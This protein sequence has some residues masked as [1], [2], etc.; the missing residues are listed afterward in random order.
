M[1]QY[2]V[3]F[4]IGVWADS[5]EEAAAKAWALLMQERTLDVQQAGSAGSDEVTIPFQEEG[6][7]DGG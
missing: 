4:E 6:K 2:T 5:A 3:T 1:K 7:T